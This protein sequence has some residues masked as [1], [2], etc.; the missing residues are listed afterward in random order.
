M[1]LSL[2]LPFKGRAFG[3]GVSRWSINAEARVRS[4]QRWKLKQIPVAARLLGLRFRIL[5]GTWMF[6]LCVVS[7]DKRQN[8]E[9]PKH[10]TKYGCSTKSARKYK[11]TARRNYM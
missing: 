8:A 7:R 4:P 6:L 2:I 5:P 1:L 3:Q 10:R 9:Q 11:K